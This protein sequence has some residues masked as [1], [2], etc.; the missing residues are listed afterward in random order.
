M[1]SCIWFSITVHKATSRSISRS[2]ISRGSFQVYHDRISEAQAKNI[3]VQIVAALMELKRLNIVHRDLKLANI[4]ITD[5]STI[6]LADFGFA[7]LM[8][9]DNLLES[10]CGTPLTMAPEI[11]K[12]R[13]FYMVSRNQEKYTD[14]CD[15]WSLGVILYQMVYGVAPFRPKAGG[16]IEDLFKVIS[17]TKLQFP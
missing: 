16:G 15:M 1:T 3:F 4:L 12:Y 11:F 17:N 10:Y 9:K 13:T 5:A 7:K 8:P 14:K 6:K 2:T